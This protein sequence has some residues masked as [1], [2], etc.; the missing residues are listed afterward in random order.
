MSSLPYNYINS[1]IDNEIYKLFLVLM[2]VDTNL[3]RALQHECSHEIYQ[4]ASYILPKYWEVD[5]DSD[6]NVGDMS[7]DAQPNFNFAA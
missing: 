6:D 3:F 1:S 2:F 5:E 4:K 7:A